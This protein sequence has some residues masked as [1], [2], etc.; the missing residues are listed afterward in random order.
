MSK[1]IVRGGKTSEQKRAF[2][3]LLVVVILG[4]CS[5]QGGSSIPGVDPS[6]LLL[7]TSAYPEGWDVCERKEYIGGRDSP[8]LTEGAEEVAFVAFGFANPEARSGETVYRFASAN[9]A[10]SK[11]HELRRI[12]FLDFPGGW[13]LP[14]GFSYLSDVATQWHFGC[15]S[16]WFR[17]ET[18]C[19]LV[20]QYDEYLVHFSAMTMVDGREVLSVEQIRALLQEIDRKMA[21]RGTAVQARGSMLLEEAD[22]VV[23][24]PRRERI[25]VR[26]LA[27]SS[28]GK[29][30]A[31]VSFL[32]IHIY[33]AQT[34]REIQLLET[35]AVVSGVAFSPDG[36]MLASASW[37]GDVRLWWVADGS[38]LRTMEGHTASVYSVAFS[39]DGEM[40]ASASWDKTVRLWRVADGSLLDTLEGHTASVNSVAFSPDGTILASAST[41]GTVRLWRVADGSPLR[42]LRGNAICWAVME[43]VAFSP[44]G[45]MLASGAMDGRVRVWRTTD[46]SLLH[47]LEGHTDWVKGVAF[48]P[49][50][51]MLASGSADGTVR[52]WRLADG[53]TRQILGALQATV[54]RVAFSPDGK[55]LVA[56]LGDGTVRLWHLTDKDN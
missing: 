54:G 43:D 38:L 45:E 30:L 28:D 20:A 44:D 2:A 16:A 5:C 47:I 53:S 13:Q 42:M 33:D 49:N 35:M 22:R 51:E 46:G 4:L 36:K 17:G 6:G 23:Q 34:L 52:L 26:G 37:D 18:I 48:S 50:G 55:T 12:H 9:E 31:A 27:Y 25:G 14:E 21:D 24:L 41:D 39:P 7:D 29:L 19:L 1:D 15:A 32:G 11:Y 8:N 40:L 10:M 3:L 56:G